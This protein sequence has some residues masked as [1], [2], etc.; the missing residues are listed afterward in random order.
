MS[1]LG[2]SSLVLLLPWLAL[3]KRDHVMHSQRPVTTMEHVLHAAVGLG[4]CALAVASVT[5][6]A[7]VLAVGLGLFLPAG[8]L[9]EGVF[10]RALP[11]EESDVHA[12]QHLALSVFVIAAVVVVLSSSPGAAVTP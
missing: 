7:A 4:V 9:D 11:A 3:A 6:D 1:L 2:L 8:V 5:T 10:H 12:K